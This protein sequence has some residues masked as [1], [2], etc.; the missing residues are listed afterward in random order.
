MEWVLYE[1]GLALGLSIDWAYDSNFE[2]REG[3]S[4]PYPT[5][6]HFFTAGEPF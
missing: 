4:Y 6:P 5:K 1:P 2:V 3:A